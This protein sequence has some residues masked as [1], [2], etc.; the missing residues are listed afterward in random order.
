MGVY[1]VGDLK[2]IPSSNYKTCKIEDV[3]RYCESKA[4]L[5]VD[6]ETEG[7]DFLSKKLLMFQIGDQEHQF[8]IDTRVISIEPLRDILQSTTICKILHNVKFDYKFIKEWAEITLENTWDTM[9]VDQ[10]IYN[11]KLNY[12]YSLAALADRY[13][14]VIVDKSI[15]NRFIDLKG[16]PF[17]DAEILYGAKDIEYLTL[18]KKYQDELIIKYDQSEIVKLENGA[19]LGLA[20][21]EYNGIKLDIPK[22]TE[23][24]AISDKEMHDYEDKL[25]Q[26]ILTN[27]AYA[28]FKS[29]YTQQNL[30]IDNSDLRKVDV[31]WSSPLQCL[32]VL[33]TVIP[34]LEDVNAK[35]LYKY[36]ANNPFID[37]YV[38]YKETA[39]L[40]TS[41]GQKFLENVGK[42]GRVHT[43]FKQILATGRIASSKP[44]MQ[45]IPA[46][47]KFRRCFITDRDHVYVSADYS[48]QELC[49][50]AVGSKDP[51][52]LKALEVGEDL[53]SICAELVYGEKWNTNA[54]PT[55]A[56]YTFEEH[57][58]ERNEVTVRH[59]KQKC[60]CPIHKELRTNVKT[61]NFGLA[62]GMGPQKLSDS[63]QISIED[64]ESL[65]EKYFSVFPSIKKFLESLGNYGKRNG[66]IKT[67]APYRRIRWFD[68]WFPGI[69][70]RHDKKKELGTIE[71]ASK[72]TPIQGTGADMTKL[73][74]VLIRA[75][76][77]DNNLNVKIV[78]TV[79]DQIDTVCHKDFAVEWAESLRNLMEDAAKQVLNTD[80]LKADPNITDKW[81]K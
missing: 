18:I 20:D 9:V 13:L 80:L 50:I 24:A 2:S 75:Y 71:R 17:D 64:A 81:E 37:G 44:N 58:D 7:L 79:H 12:R 61:I 53:H 56:Y 22:W 52:W 59:K 66:Y 3:V 30:F 19:A 70:T 36:R 42:D 41:Y 21:I 23:I 35:N 57:V 11:G 74:L 26:Y 67:F 45:Q 60:N 78:M 76:I 69:E 34:E 28:A 15:R 73:A 51:V 47:N 25:D 43:N 38:K 10:V 5:G 40:A 31:K 14:N 4:I 46:D 16:Q 48:S 49:I 29:K 63:L 6:T 55:C 39:K 27:D 65:I 77:R 54:E 72:N 8:I 33:Q 32:K 68:E 62:Y 1:F